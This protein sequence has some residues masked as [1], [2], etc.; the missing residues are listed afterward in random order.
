MPGLL[1]TNRLLVSGGRGD[2]RQLGRKPHLEDAMG[3]QLRFMDHA[4]EPV[5]E[6][7]QRGFFSTVGV[8]VAWV[9]TTTPF[10]V[11]AALASGMTFW[12]AIAALLVGTII[13]ATVGML[14]GV[15]GQ[16][17]RMNSYLISRIVYGAK[18][19]TLISVL[20]GVL[21]VGFVGVIASLLGAVVSAGMTF[22]PVW[23]GSLAFV[24]FSTF[25]ALVGY[26]G[27]SVVG[28]ISVPL[29]WAL[30]IFLAIKTLGTGGG[31]GHITS[32]VPKGS[33][34]FGVAV[35]IVVADWIT[36]ATIACDIARFS[37]R[38]RDV[39]IASY[40]GWVVSYCLFALIGLFAYYGSGSTN[41]VGLL[42]AQGLIGA[43]IF[44]FF[45]AL[46][47]STDVNLY[48]FSLA[49]N[50]L[51]DAFGIKQLKRAAW[52]LIGGII[53]AL[54]SLLGYANTFLP[55][56]LTIGVIIP[57]YAGVVL[58]HYY[59]LGARSKTP[60]ALVAGIEPGVRWTGMVSFVVGVAVA[61][62][63]N[64]ANIGL[65]ALQGLIVAGL[66]YTALEYGFSRRPSP[67]PATTAAR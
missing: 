8:F 45:V 21:S 9:I 57:A 19:S 28:Q 62:I 61:Y 49:L 2:A 6:K 20:I 44:V 58:A 23:V 48:A 64:R 12:T 13:T 1:S 11:A 5:P 27:L 46:I 60:E 30:G 40:L 36:G 34:S 50:N 55:F 38:S 43:A 4:L 66:L 67:T 33:L 63:T 25:I 31:F 65:P 59:L 39:A 41:I 53:T 42:A 54:I 37:K 47:S 29:L 24:I 3:L 52:V 14:V 35:T 15:L 16:R 32:V 7:D 10:L 22:L 51:C 56:L 17:T 26:R 18:G